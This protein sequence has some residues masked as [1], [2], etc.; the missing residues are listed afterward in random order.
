MST[1]TPTHSSATQPVAMA[2]DG[3]VYD[4]PIFSPYASDT[5]ATVFELPADG[6]PKPEF[7]AALAAVVA[8]A[9]VA[10]VQS[11]GIN[12][13][14]VA[15]VKRAMAET[16]GLISLYTTLKTTYLKLCKEFNYLLQLF[17]ENERV[18]MELIKE[19]NQLRQTVAELLSRQPE[20]RSG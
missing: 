16:L 11:V 1:I 12:M 20:P 5:P 19:N 15:Q 13:D 7:A 8:P 3:G 17:K 14:T 18:K 6:D 9:G 4:T 2:F 10:P